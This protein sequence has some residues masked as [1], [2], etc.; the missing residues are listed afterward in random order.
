MEARQRYEELF[1]HPHTVELTH[2][3]IDA[4]DLRRLVMRRPVSPGAFEV[5]EPPSPT[6]IQKAALAALAQSRMDNFQRGLV[7][8]ATGLGKTWL[9]RV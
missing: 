4:Y 5:V 8:L 6:T 1:A 3:W 7:V 2:D 9:C